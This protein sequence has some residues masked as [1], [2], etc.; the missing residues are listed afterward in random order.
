[1]KIIIARDIKLELCQRQ[2]KYDRPF[3][4]SLENRTVDDSD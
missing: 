3:K 4:C 2:I 1:M